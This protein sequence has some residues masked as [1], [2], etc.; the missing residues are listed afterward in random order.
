VLS[1]VRLVKNVIW[2]TASPQRPPDDNNAEETTAVRHIR[3][4]Q[5]VRAPETDKRLDELNENVLDIG[6][7]IIKILINEV[8]CLKE[9]I[10]KQQ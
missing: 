1:V 10:N 4:V 5:E 3:N 6:E 8:E 2:F 9:A 7:N